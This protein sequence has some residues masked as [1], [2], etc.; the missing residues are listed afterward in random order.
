MYILTNYISSL[1]IGNWI[2][3]IIMW[4][5]HC[6]FIFKGNAMRKYRVFNKVLFS[7]VK[8]EIQIGI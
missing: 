8:L 4:S 5:Y 6:Q 1:D 3:I 7:V 2:Q